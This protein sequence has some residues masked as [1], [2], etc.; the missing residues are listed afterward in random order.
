LHCASVALSSMRQAAPR[1][2]LALRYSFSSALFASIYYVYADELK[3][4]KSEPNEHCN[5]HGCVLCLWCMAR[6]KLKRKKIL[7]GAVSC[8]LLM[9]VGV[10]IWVGLLSNEDDDQVIAP[11]SIEDIQIE[12]AQRLDSGDSGGGLTYY[13]EM[14]ELEQQDD[15]KQLLLVNKSSFALMAKEYV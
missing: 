9:L 5:G 7:V 6:V 12:A 2:R 4:A 14:V 8:F 1:G 13:D 11:Q 15:K 3:R 10:T